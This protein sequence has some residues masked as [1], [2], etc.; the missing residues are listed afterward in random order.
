MSA[1]DTFVRDCLAIIAARR[2]R[3][4]LERKEA[5]LRKVMETL[6]EV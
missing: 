1:L 5:A 4:A 3:E 6:R 2:R